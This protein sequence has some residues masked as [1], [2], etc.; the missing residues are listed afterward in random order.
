MKTTRTTTGLLLIVVLACLG[1]ML[2]VIPPKIAAILSS[3]PQDTPQT[4]LRTN[5]SGQDSLMYH[6]HSTQSIA[7]GTA[8]TGGP[9]A[10]IRT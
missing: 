1:V 6:L 7:V 4:N 10:Q 2:L 5:L 9:P 3:L 8:V